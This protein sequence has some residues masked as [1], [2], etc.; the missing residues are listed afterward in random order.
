MDFTEAQF[1]KVSFRNATFSNKADFT[2][3]TFSE[4]AVFLG[5]LRRI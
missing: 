2:N 3:A 4:Q 1:K 5:T